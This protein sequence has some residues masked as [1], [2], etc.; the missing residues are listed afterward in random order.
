MSVSLGTPCFGLWILGL[1]IGVSAQ[2]QADPL[3]DFTM[4]N[5]P[6]AAQRKIT[7]PLTSWVVQAD[8]QAF[9]DAAQPKDGMATRPEGCVFWLRKDSRCTIVTTGSTTHSQLGHLFLQCIKAE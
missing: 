5:P 9:C 1:A 2:A 3:L 4:F 8:P 7:E 6:P